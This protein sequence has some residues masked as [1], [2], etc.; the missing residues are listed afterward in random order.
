[1]PPIQPYKGSLEI[2]GNL[3]EWETTFDQKVKF[4]CTN[5][6]YCCESSNVVLSFEDMQNIPSAFQELRDDEKTYIRD[7]DHST[8]PFL[9]KDTLCSIYE[10]RPYVCREYPFKVSFVSKNKVYIDLIHACESIIKEDYLPDNE[11]D[12]SFLVRKS[13]YKQLLAEKPNLNFTFLTDEEIKQTL[14]EPYDW[15]ELKIKLFNLLKQ[16]SG[17]PYKTMGIYTNKFYII[18]ARDNKII[19]SD[20]EIDINTLSNKLFTEEAMFMLYTYISMLFTRKLTQI[21]FANAVCAL[22]EHSVK[23]SDKDIQKRAINRLYLTMLF[24]LNIIAEKNNHNTITSLDVKEAIFLLD[25]TFLAP[26]EGIIKPFL[27]KEKH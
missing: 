24:F 26:M 14:S 23:I 12:F 20:K 10:K 25:T 2:D 18:T 8:C 22:K 13:Y 5:C 4:K 17:N 9:T 21:D 19:A 27:N 6:G 1:M 7:T 15:N 16:T 3:V 11:V